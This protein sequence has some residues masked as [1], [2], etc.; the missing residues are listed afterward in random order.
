[1][2]GK[3]LVLG[4]ESDAGKG[5]TSAEM[6]DPV[7]GTWTA[8]GN[9]LRPPTFPAWAVLLHDGTV[10]AGDAV[11]D[12]ASGTWTATN[13]LVQLLGR[14]YPAMALPS[15]RA[16]VTALFGGA[17]LYDPA[18]QAWTATGEMNVHRENAAA[19][20]LSDGKVLVAGGIVDDGPVTN[21]A[22]VYDP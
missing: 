2:D 3:V 21:S 13:P 1:L 9:M 19:A 10:L 15:G 11:Y 14:C 5:L 18:R 16:L 22:E 12:P 6:Y 8:T 7:T 17:E 20:L 4:G